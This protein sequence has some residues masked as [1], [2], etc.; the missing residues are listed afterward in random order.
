M[1]MAIVLVLRQ[2]LFTIKEA[3]GGWSIELEAFLLLTA[4]ALVFLGGGRYRI[5]RAPGRWD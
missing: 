5:G 1:V 4:L 3:G 2:D